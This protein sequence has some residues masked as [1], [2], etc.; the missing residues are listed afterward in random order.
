MKHIWTETEEEKCCE[1]FVKYYVVEKSNIHYNDVIKKLTV[2]LN[3]D[4]QE[5]SLR[6][7]FSNIT[8]ILDFYGVKNSC[9][10]SPLQNWSKRNER[11]LIQVL[12]DNGIKI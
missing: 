9:T 4:I 10:I 11:I 3:G 6:M 7:K 2:M 8:A 5:G 12:R 1:I